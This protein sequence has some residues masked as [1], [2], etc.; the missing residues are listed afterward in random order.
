VAK[1]AVVEIL[2]S[3]LAEHPAAVAWCRVA[4]RSGAPNKI[5]ILKET[6]NSTVYRLNA[7]GP[8]STAVIAKWCTAAAAAIERTVYEDVLPILPVTALRFYGL[9]SEDGDVV[10]SPRRWLFLED[11]G[12]EKYSC[13]LEEH[14]A[15]AGRWLGT[16]HFSAAHLRGPGC[17]P[18][19]GPGHYLAEL[20]SS[21][22]T[23]EQSL[24]NPVMNAG[25]AMV[26]E[27]ILAQC[28]ILESHWGEVDQL[29]SRMPQT[30]VHGDLAQKN[31]RV[32]NGAAGSS[33]MLIDWAG[34]GW[35]P[36]AID[37]AQFTARSLSPD[38]GA[39]SS[40]FDGCWPGARSVAQVAEI[41]SIF[42][43]IVAMSWESQSLLSPWLSRPMKK[44][45]VYQ[46][47]MADC[48]RAAG[49][50]N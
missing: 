1:D 17:L 39:Y 26:L 45:R 9:A 12:D 13:L 49:W 22:E 33:L 7:V 46:D 8:R 35:G 6:R 29:S 32:R 37:L 34:A 24:A 2:D 50:G 11:A 36:P 21:Q 38:L 15:L 10:D 23:I 16:M 14:R 27:A 3:D 28:R 48:I 31:A 41:G 5:T 25:D 40:C 47:A 18:D 43:L 4:P 42:R 20:R 44:M 19:R 30:L